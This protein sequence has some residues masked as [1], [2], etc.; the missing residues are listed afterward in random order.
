MLLHEVR[1]PERFHRWGDGGREKVYLRPPGKMELI[2]WLLR[3][4]CLYILT[5]ANVY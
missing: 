1:E 4:L 3:E 5:I 2:E